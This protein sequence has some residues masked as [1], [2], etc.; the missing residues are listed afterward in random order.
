MRRA[1]PCRMK[2]D[3]QISKNPESPSTHHEEKSPPPIPITTK[4]MPS[5]SEAGQ[6]LRA[7][8]S[9]RNVDFSGLTGGAWDVFHA[10]NFQSNSPVAN[11]WLRQ[12]NN[13]VAGAA[14]VLNTVN[15]TA[16]M[17]LSDAPRFLEDQLVAAGGP[18]F[19][20]LTVAARSAT[21]GMPLDDIAS[22]GL[23]RIAELSHRIRPRL[24]GTDLPLTP[25][26]LNHIQVGHFSGW[27]KRLRKSLFFPNVDPKSLLKKAGK[28]PRRPQDGGNFERIVRSSNFVGIDR[29]SMEATQTYTVITNAKNKV[30][31]M[32]PGK[33]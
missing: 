16:G 15:N 3:R 32:F 8:E 12:I 23:A 25:S 19:D 21:P 24:F 10:S 9:K 22:Y 29:R 1:K 14:I 27:P 26:S 33:P 4:P 6:K 30:I 20:E 11:A 17:L 13:S 7:L 31:T 5:L 18:S 28:V 2:I